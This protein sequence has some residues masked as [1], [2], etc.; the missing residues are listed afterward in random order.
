MTIL[1][2]G[3]GGQLGRELV[4]RAG[5][6]DLVGLDRAQWDV[7]DPQATEEALDRHRPVVVINAAAHTAVDQAESE[8]QRAFAVNRDGVAQLARACAARGIPLLHLSTCYVFDG[9][10]RSPYTEDDPPA[11][12]NVYGRSKWEG[13]QALRAALP[14]HVTLRV[15]WVF[16]AHGD[17]FVGAM[18]R[19]ARAGAP[20]RVVADQ[21]GTPTHAGAIARA[22]LALAGRIEAGEELAW[23]T[24]HYPGGPAVSWHAF[25]QAILAE[26]HRLGLLD[27]APEVA[28]ITSA[29]YPAP[30]RRPAYSVLDGTRAYRRLGLPAADWRAGLEEVLSTWKQAT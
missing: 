14:R 30:A 29:E 22:L 1:V 19:R 27:A 18:L 7:A 20:L 3:A 13:E 24:C 2:S 6:R 25:A 23:G 16:G 11:P 5:R 8:P 26:A 21:V 15:S 4:R 28:A 9:Q 17:N 10:K 12:L